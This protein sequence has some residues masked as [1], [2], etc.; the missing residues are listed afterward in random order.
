MYYIYITNS[1]RIMM[2]QHE[3]NDKYGKILHFYYFQLYENYSF[4]HL[5]FFYYD[6]V[7]VNI[8]FKYLNIFILLL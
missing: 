8:N 5:Q 3:N 6:S 4:T 2:T 1:N 7:F